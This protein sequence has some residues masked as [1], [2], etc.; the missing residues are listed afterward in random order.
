MIAVLLFKASQFDDDITID[1]LEVHVHTL[2]IPAGLYITL[3]TIRCALFYI[4]CA[5]FYIIHNSLPIHILS[6]KNR[7]ESTGRDQYIP[8]KSFR[9]KPHAQLN[10]ADGSLSLNF[11]K[12][13]DG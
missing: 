10:R 12:P 8:G 6:F 7:R 9:T 3:N 2:R 1:L 4:R 5:Q 13:A 11:L